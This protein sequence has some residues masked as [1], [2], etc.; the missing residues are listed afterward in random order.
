MPKFPVCSLQG[1]PGKL[2]ARPVPLK[3]PF[4]PQRWSASAKYAIANR[5]HVLG[6]VLMT[7]ADDEALAEQACAQGIAFLRKPFHPRIWKRCY[8]A[9]AVCGR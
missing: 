5:R 4:M 9:S 3:G 2:R 7:S 6:G 1:R 8:A